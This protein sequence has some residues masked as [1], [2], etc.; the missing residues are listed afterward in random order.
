MLLSGK[1]VLITG[2]SKGIGNAIA[3]VFADNGASCLLLSRN[4]E[5]LDRLKHELNVHVGQSH[6]SFACDVS[7]YAQ[8]KEVFVYLRK[9]NTRIDIVVN[10]AGIMK[11][12]MIGMMPEEVL[13]EIYSTNVY[14]SYYIAQQASKFMLK[15]RSGSIINLSSIVGTN[16]NKGQTAYASSK[17]AIIGLTKSLSKELAAFNIR[18]NAIA[19]GFIATDMTA[20]MEPIFYT[21]NLSMIGMR[22]MGEPEDIANAALFLASD[23]SKYVTGQTIG[24]DGGFLI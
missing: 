1:S 12:A 15:N 19:P 3:Q 23:L 24:V 20:G 18:V 11:D 21:K 13:K 5:A 10:N 22:R 8:V 4:I 6:Q 14:G 2:A 17:A 16:G 9:S 7:N